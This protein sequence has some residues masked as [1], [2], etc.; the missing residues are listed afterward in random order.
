MS[1]KDQKTEDLGVKIGTEDE[2]LWTK[3]R[4]ETK[5]TIKQMEDTVKINREILYLAETKI[6]EEQKK[7]AA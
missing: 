6:L 4:D 2:V 3:V 1:K 5:M 7:M